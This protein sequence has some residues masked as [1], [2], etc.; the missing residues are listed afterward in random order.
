W[1]AIDCMQLKSTVKDLPLASSL[2]GTAINSMVVQ[3]LEAIAF[4]GVLGNSVDVDLFGQADTKE[5]AKSLADAARGLV[6]L[7]R[8]GAG[9]D[10][11]KEWLD[12]LDGI[13]VDQSG[14]DVSLRVSIP[15]KSM[16]SF[17]AQMTTRSQPVAEPSAGAPP[18][19]QPAASPRAPAPSSGPAV[20]GKEYRRPAPGP[21]DMQK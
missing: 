1:G 18:K 7:G 19:E 15:A 14:A 3:S 2:G 16:E 11:A 4:R 9:R 6:A 17:V 5:N 10:Q 13:R 8:V 12:F 20:E 21:S